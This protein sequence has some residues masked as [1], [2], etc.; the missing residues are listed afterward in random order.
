M[1]AVLFAVLTHVPV[2]GSGCRGVAVLTTA[3][4]SREMRQDMMETD[5]HFTSTSLLLF[6]VFEVVS[7]M[8]AC[9]IFVDGVGINVFLKNF[10][11]N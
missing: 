5:C 11:G 8:M 6:F 4:K 9:A 2:I 1:I 7:L 3:R 10:S